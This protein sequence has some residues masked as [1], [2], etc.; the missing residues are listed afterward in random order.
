M[1]FDFRGIETG[2]LI[3]NRQG[4]G[5]GQGGIEQVGVATNKSIA[6]FLILEDFAQQ[7]GGIVA[8]SKEVKVTRFRGIGEAIK[9][10]GAA[11]HIVVRQTQREIGVHQHPTPTTVVPRARPV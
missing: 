5:G 11:R 1:L 3:E 8:L 2:E 4:M 7:Q 10:R 6:H 9:T